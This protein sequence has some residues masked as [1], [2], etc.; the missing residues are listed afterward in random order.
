M[1]KKIGFACGVSGVDDDGETAGV[2]E[3]E[4]DK[5]TDVVAVVAEADTDDEAEDIKN[6]AVTADAARD[7]GCLAGGGPANKVL[8]TLGDTNISEKGPKGTD[9][10]DK[11]RKGDGAT[12]SLSEIEE[13]T[14][15]AAAAV[16]EVEEEDEEP[17]TACG[18]QEIVAAAAL[19][20]RE[21]HFITSLSSLRLFKGA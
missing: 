11:E 12:F 8:R 14:R 13:T 6:E 7:C 10:A 4:D 9:D 19:S 15:C 5:G 21:L 20:G 17:R 16:D 2:E 18:R 3:D 1:E